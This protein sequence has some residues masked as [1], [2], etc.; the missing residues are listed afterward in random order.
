MSRKNILFFIPLIFILIPIFNPGCGES[1]SKTS[2]KIYLPIEDSATLSVNQ[3]VHF[4]GQLQLPLI[5]ESYFIEAEFF[6]TP[7]MV[8]R[9]AANIAS[10]TD[11]SNF[12]ILAAGNRTSCDKDGNFSISNV[13]AGDSFLF[14]GISER[15]QLKKRV[16]FKLDDGSKMG[17][18]ILNLKSTA[19]ALL[20]DEALKNGKYISL[21]SL[22]T[23]SYTSEIESILLEQLQN[24]AALVG[25]NILT[26]QKVQSTLEYLVSKL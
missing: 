6:N 26:T 11:L 19:I 5:H 7:T 24:D 22:E 1:I 14:T 16:V 8:A 12:N 17:N 2:P 21:T 3:G 15:I 25:K 4:T 10:A 13:P 9:I 20:Y 18:I 23:H